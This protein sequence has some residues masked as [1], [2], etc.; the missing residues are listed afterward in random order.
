M[1]LNNEITIA[2]NKYIELY[3]YN[4]EIINVITKTIK[5]INPYSE[6]LTFNS[7]QELYDAFF[8]NNKKEQY[9][10]NLFFDISNEFIEKILLKSHYVEGDVYSL[11]ITTNIQKKIT[12]SVIDEEINYIEIENEYKIN[13][14]F[15][16]LIKYNHHDNRKIKQPLS[17]HFNFNDVFKENS[18]R[19]QQH[20]RFK[21]YCT[22]KNCKFFYG[23]NAFDARVED[24]KIKIRLL[25]TNPISKMVGHN[26]IN[27]YFDFLECIENK[28]I[29]NFYE[30]YNFN[31]EVVL[32]D[33]AL[34]NELFREFIEKHCRLSILEHI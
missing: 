7:L 21:I 10:F 11:T 27:L 16:Y 8:I 23:V 31:S 18:C 20:P 17:L 1:N 15:S 26:N 19:V 12:Y 4:K 3:K 29:F 28:S 22:D 32:L 24:N 9:A 13:E 34:H 33:F 14:E 30:N 2:N 25:F 6:E 5:F